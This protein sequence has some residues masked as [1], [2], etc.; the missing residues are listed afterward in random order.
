MQGC[1][2]YDESEISS[3]CTGFRFGL[4][5]SIRLSEF[6]IFSK[7]HFSPQNSNQ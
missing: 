2:K 5:F 6:F 1:K 3:M 7:I 4:D